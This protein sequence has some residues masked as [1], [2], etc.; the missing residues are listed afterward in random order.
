MGK[1]KKYHL[2][3]VDFTITPA[4][5]NDKAVHALEKAGFVYRSR[6]GKTEYYSITK[7]KTSWL[8]LYVCIG[9]L[10][11]MILAIVL[12]SAPIGMLLGILICVAIGAGMDASENKARERVTGE[13]K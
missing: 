2:K 13:K 10:V 8:G 12:G 1:V 4:D 5:E 11:G 6:E 9:I 3:T 7:Q